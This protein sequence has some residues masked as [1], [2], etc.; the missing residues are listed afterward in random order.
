MDPRDPSDPATP[1]EPAPGAS[2]P[3][4]ARRP[5][6]REFDYFSDGQKP[7][8]AGSA[9]AAELP[10]VIEEQLE[11]AHHARRRALG[12]ALTASI[13]VAA[14][15]WLVW[16]LR[17]PMAYAFSSPRPPLRLGE[18]VDF[19]PADI[20]HN[21]YVELGGITE[22]RGLTQKVV[23]LPSLAQKELW[24]FRLVGS[25]GVFLETPP[26]PQRF[27]LTTSL[28]VRGRAVDPVRSPTYQQ[29]LLDYQDH[30]RARPQ[31]AARIIQVDVAPGEGRLPYALLLGFIV[32][33]VAF[34]GWSLWS[35]ARHL[36]PGAGLLR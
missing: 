8:A 26:D 21:A 3:V 22:H 10:E 25:R 36:R 28:L 9:A 33:L 15:C 5:S 14:S 34:D 4:P 11:R 20:P 24:Y 2:G 32:L 29:L 35:Y 17:D 6:L 16:G 13:L 31:D 23:R 27:G 30:F 18:V 12:S 19:T 1:P 7:V